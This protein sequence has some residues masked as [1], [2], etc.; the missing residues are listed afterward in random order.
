MGALAITYA[1]ILRGGRNCRPMR[2]EDRVFYRALIMRLQDQLKWN[3]MRVTG[4][5]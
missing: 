3:G 2:K 5:I 4:H 1:S